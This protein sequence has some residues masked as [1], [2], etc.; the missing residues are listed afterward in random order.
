[1]SQ[2][3][4]ESLTHANTKCE[5]LSLVFHPMTFFFFQNKSFLFL[6]FITHWTN[7]QCSFDFIKSHVFTHLWATNFWVYTA[8]L[9][10]SVI[11]SNLNIVGLSP[12]GGGGGGIYPTHVFFLFM[13]CNHETHFLGLCPITEL[14]THSPRMV[15]DHNPTHTP[16]TM[17]C[18]RAYE[19]QRCYFMPYHFTCI[20]RVT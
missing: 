15:N 9:P 10:P 20:M 12:W 19:M 4:T 2:V 3:L 17:R 13:L 11:M 1:M 5:N 8:R 16:N 14:T 18:P 7:F 6:K